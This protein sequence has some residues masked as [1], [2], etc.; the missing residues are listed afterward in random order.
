MK[1][2]ILFPNPAFNELNL[3]LDWTSTAQTGHFFIRNSEGKAVA[4]KIQE[5]KNGFNVINFDID[6]LTGGIY[7]VELNNANSEN[8][9]LDRFV[10]VYS[11]SIDDLS[12]NQKMNNGKDR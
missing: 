8:I 3:N 10:K 11:A 6:A 4:E 9:P 5:L 1:D 2:F 7:S 12:K